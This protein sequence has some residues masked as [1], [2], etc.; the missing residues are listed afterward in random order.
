TLLFSCAFCMFAYNFGDAVVAELDSGTE[1][2]IVVASFHRSEGVVDVQPQGVI[3][4]AIQEQISQHQ[5]SRASVTVSPSII[6]PGHE[7]ALQQ[8]QALGSDLVIWGTDT[9]LF[10]EVHLLNQQGIETSDGSA[11]PAVPPA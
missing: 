3:R 8:A 2:S 9:G 6:K 5:L 11:A 7:Q 4:D 1:A 10:L